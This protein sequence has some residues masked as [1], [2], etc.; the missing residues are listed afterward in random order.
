MTL[1]VGIVVT[2]KPPSRPGS[3]FENSRLLSTDPI[4]SGGSVKSQS[5]PLPSSSAK[6]SQL[7]S[8][9]RLLR[10]VRISSSPKALRQ[11]AME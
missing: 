4:A 11:V 3:Q 5:A 6:S 9:R 7:R 8:R 2:A 1:S 10:Q